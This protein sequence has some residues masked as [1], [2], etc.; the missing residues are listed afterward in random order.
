MQLRLNYFYLKPWANLGEADSLR[1]IVKIDGD[2]SKWSLPSIR[3]MEDQ[4]V[5]YLI[6]EVIAGDKP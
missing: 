5:V 3:L 4:Q 1:V 2:V 6:N